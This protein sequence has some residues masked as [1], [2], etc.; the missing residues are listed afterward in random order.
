M[1]SNNNKV[2]IV[3][4]GSRGIGAAVA[5][6][7]AS[8]GFAVVINYATTPK[9]ADELVKKIKG[10]GGR[11]LA[12]G[13]DIADPRVAKDL[14]DQGEKTFGGIDVL[15]NSAGAMVIAPLSSIDD[16]SIDKLLD[17]NIKGS[18]YCMREAAGRMREGGSIINFSSSVTKLLQPAMTV[19][20]ATKA[21]IEAITS[22]LS[23][24]LGDKKIRVNAVAPGP[25]A[26]DLLKDAPKES[27]DHLTAMTPLKRLGQ[28]A[29]ISSVISFLAGPESGWVNGQTIWVNGGII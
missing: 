17:V 23:K 3:T 29:D 21:A 28:P 12:V 14:F 26:T 25:V 5:E 4:G 27:L 6:R 13:G 20:G 8:D 1:S 15:V 2:A 24:E 10:A 18:L 11:A 22:I 16:A 9:P 7:L 19:Y